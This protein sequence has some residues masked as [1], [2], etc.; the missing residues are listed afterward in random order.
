MPCRLRDSAHEAHETPA[1][2]PFVCSATDLDTA[3]VAKEGLSTHEAMNR[4]MAILDGGA[5]KTL[6]SVHAVEQL[7]LLNQK[8]HGSDGIKRI[9]NTLRPTFGFGN[10]SSDKCMSTAWLRVQAGGR[11]GEL[12]VH[13]LDRGSSPHFV[14]HRN[15]EGSW[16]HY[17]FCKSSGAQSTELHLGTNSSLLQSPPEKGRWPMPK[18]IWEAR[19]LKLRELLILFRVCLIL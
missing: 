17:R 3:H 13:T 7:T 6:G 2:A 1:S 18:R 9:D 16:S 5:T 10:S 4:G 12:K 14:Q 8:N 11:D 19:S 15:A